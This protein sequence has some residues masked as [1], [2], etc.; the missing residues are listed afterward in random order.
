MKPRAL[1]DGDLCPQD[2]DHGR[3]WVLPSTRQFCPAAAHRGNYLYLYDGVTPVTSPA[4]DD[5]PR[6]RTTWPEPNPLEGS[7]R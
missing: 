3:M 1:G 2:P 4:L 7:V 5:S 6:G